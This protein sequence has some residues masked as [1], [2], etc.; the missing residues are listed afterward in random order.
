[1]CISNIYLST[2]F[3]CSWLC[4]FLNTGYTIDSISTLSSESILA[5]TVVS[6]SS[7]LSDVTHSVQV[8]AEDMDAYAPKDLLIVT[9][10]SQV[11]YCR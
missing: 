10:G 4:A 3:I 6:L 7:S 9:T 11:S 2:V 5:F 1:M 8:K